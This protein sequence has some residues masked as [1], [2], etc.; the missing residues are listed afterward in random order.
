MLVPGTAHIIKNQNHSYCDCFVGPYSHICSWD[1][2][3]KYKYRYVF[4]VLGCPEKVT[5]EE[6]V[7]WR[8]HQTK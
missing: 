5:T 4:R 8:R 2:V 7:S 3:F 6:T 1:T